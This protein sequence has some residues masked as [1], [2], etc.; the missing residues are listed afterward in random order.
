MA[1]LTVAEV[2]AG[3]QTVESRARTRSLDFRPPRL[4]LRPIVDRSTLP[5]ALPPLLRALLVE[6]GTIDLHARFLPGRAEALGFSENTWCALE[7][8]FPSTLET[9]DGETWLR[10][11]GNGNGRIHAL[12]QRWNVLDFDHD[13]DPSCA[14]LVAKSFDLFMEYRLRDGFL[15]SDDDVT[16]AAA[17]LLR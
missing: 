4:A 15:W 11:G 14:K 7:L 8:D 3:V 16:R 2:L 9:T 6:V 10:F 1:T 17:W 12:D 5:P 13:E